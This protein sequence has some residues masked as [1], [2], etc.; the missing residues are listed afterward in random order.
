MSR[1]FIV[2]DDIQTCELLKE[3]AE[4]L[5]TEVCVYNDARLFLQKNIYDTD[6]V[7]LDLMMPEIDGIEVIR[8]LAKRK[9][10]AYLVLISGYDAGVLHSAE[11]LARDHGLKVSGDYTK[12]ISIVSLMDLLAELLEEIEQEQ[13]T[14][15]ITE[16]INNYDQDVEID[17]SLRES[18]TKLLFVP[19]FDDLKHAIYQ[20]Q[21]QLHYQPQLQITTGKL[22]GV[23]A[24]VRW[25]HPIHGLIFPD[26]FIPLAEQTGLIEDLTSSVIDIAVGQSALWKKQGFA[27]KISVNIS[28]KNITSL[29]LPEQLSSLVT[30][31]QIDP[32]MMVLEVTESAL[33]GELTT[34]LDILTRLRLKGFQLSIDD[35]G[36]G[37]SSLSQLHRVPF[38]ELKIDR[39][40]IAKMNQDPES[41][42]IVETCI[43]LGHKL[44]MEVVAEGIEDQAIW[45]LLSSLGCDIGQGYHV[46]K[47]M[48]AEELLQWAQKLNVA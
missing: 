13:K 31:N 17:D 35:F 46:A 12:P 2:D 41:C 21:L 29:Q 39:S 6:I 33:M 22:I 7:L 48:V 34:S 43:M 10:R 8:H 24:L 30:H 5:F 27:V 42:A 9:S 19:D 36:T 37:F 26:Q 44:N 23:E 40:F 20:G 16:P 4:V 3:A 11:G 28:S 15:Q 14:F 1:L 47:P 45:N 25:Q 18:V 38:T 32:S